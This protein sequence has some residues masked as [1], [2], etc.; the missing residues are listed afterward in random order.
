[1]KILGY[2]SPDKQNDRIIDEIEDINVDVVPG[3]N[4]NSQQNSEADT[5]VPSDYPRG[6]HKNDAS[7][8]KPTADGKF[9]CLETKEVIPYT[10]VNDDF[11]DCK[12]SSDEPGTAACPNSRFYCT[13]QWPGHDPQFVPTSRVND[14]ICDCCDGSDEWEGHL[15]PPQIRITDKSKRYSIFQAPCEN[16]CARVIRQLDEEKHIRSIG[17]NIKKEYLEIGKGHS[18]EFGPDGAFYKL[19]KVCF[20]FQTPEYQYTVCPFKMVKQQHFPRPGVTIGKKPVWKSMTKGSYILEMTDGD[21][22]LCPNNGV[23]STTIYFLC[24]LNDKVI[25]IMEDEKCRYIAKFSTPAAC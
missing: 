1:M 20:P 7:S 24:G 5:N 2:S 3:N 25:K 9:I 4:V 21:R 14:G 22:K 18:N 13:F 23:R 6:V 15:V 12:D 17:E 11:C 16:R 8:Y 19:S 10:Y